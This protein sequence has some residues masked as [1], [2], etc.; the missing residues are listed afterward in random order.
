MSLR[1]ELVNKMDLS[2]QKIKVDKKTRTLS[3][4]WNDSHLT[5]IRFGLL[6]AACP[7][8][9]CRGGHE[10]MK[11]EPDQVVFSSNL[12]DSPMTAIDK[13]D[14][15]GSYGLTILWGDGH[16]YG[17][18]TWEYLRALCTCDECNAKRGK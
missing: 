3:I 2:P 6:R 16:H 10:N 5:D 11:S 14:P 9:S 7:C 18:Y 13:V 17:I 15:V 8:A 1:K 12:P 4:V